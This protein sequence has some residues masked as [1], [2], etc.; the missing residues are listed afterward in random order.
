MLVNLAFRQ[1]FLAY[2][3]GDAAY[4]AFFP[5][6]AICM[7]LTWLVYLRAATRRGRAGV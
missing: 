7:S 4:L 5:F 1:S 2:R 6:Y 3:T